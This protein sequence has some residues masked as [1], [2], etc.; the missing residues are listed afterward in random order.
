MNKDKIT[1]YELLKEEGAE[2]YPLYRVSPSAQKNRSKG[3]GH[4][5]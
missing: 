2:G 1:A 5:K 4:R 3:N